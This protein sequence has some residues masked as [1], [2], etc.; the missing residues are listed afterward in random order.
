MADQ[1]MVDF[2]DSDLSGNLGDRAPAV[3]TT[4]EP[5]NLTSALADSL[6]ASTKIGEFTDSMA[7][8]LDS[9]NVPIG[10]K[11]PQDPIDSISSSDMSKVSN[12]LN[13]RPGASALPQRGPPTGP[14]SGPR[15]GQRLTQLPPQFS[16]EQT[17][18]PPQRGPQRPHR[19]GPPTGGGRPPVR[20][21]DPRASVQQ[22]MKSIA[23]RHNL[24]NQNQA[25]N[26]AQNQ[27]QTQ[28]N[29]VNNRS[30][31]DRAGIIDPNQTN[32]QV[33]ANDLQ[34]D[35]QP[36]E[37][38]QLQPQDGGQPQPQDSEQLQ[39]GE[40]P[41]VQGAQP[42]IPD[43]MTSMMG[44]SI[45]TTTLYLILVLVL[46]AV[47]L[48]FWTAPPAPKDKSKGKKK[49]KEEEEEEDDE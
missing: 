8:S 34:G 35:G 32:G 4:R 40:Q 47:G 41:D 28:G 11:L 6:A 9:P 27:T 20:M 39:G 30:V 16:Q 18:G 7:D 21:P 24:Q 33:Q 1:T 12:R 43:H 22:T 17:R 46:I 38:G 45:P 14:P 48:Y 44:Y 31:G 36:Q 19:S 42:V 23:A 49:K 15:P 25:Q 13:G 2:S 37:G 10:I 26:Q 5:E 29:P 3:I